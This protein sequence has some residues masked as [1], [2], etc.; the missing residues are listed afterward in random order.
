MFDDDGVWGLVKLLGTVAPDVNT[1]RATCGRVWPHPSASPR[2]VCIRAFGGA[3][4]GVRM[5]EPLREGMFRRVAARHCG[6]HV[7]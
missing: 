5:P 7:I 4:V 6:M 3:R 1:N 2:T